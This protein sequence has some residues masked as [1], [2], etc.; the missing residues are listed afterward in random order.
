[1]H[2]KGVELSINFL[3]IMII[4]LT[5]FGFGI[6][7][8]S[9]LSSQANEL[10]DMTLGELDQRIGE[11]ICE[12]SARV[13]IGIERQ[14]IRKE[15]LGVFGLKILNLDDAQ[16]FEVTVK[17]SNPIGFDSNNKPIL[18]TGTFDGLDITPPVYTT[19][20]AVSIDKNEEET[21]GIGIHVPKEA[22][23][24][25]Y[26]F[27]VDIKDGS[28]NVYSKTQKIYVDVQ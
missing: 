27:N 13:C 22:I 5:V 10:A 21:V 6:Y 14:A 18:V 12:G 25:T 19:A 11:L 7:F 16:Q 4:S 9:R 15:K 28:G 17:P 8:I 26:I 2:K 1:M 24:G 23:P 20:R 3:V